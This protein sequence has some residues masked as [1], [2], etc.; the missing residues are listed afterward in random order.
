MLTSAQEHLEEEATWALG[1]GELVH[2]LIGQPLPSMRMS[3]TT[4]G[5]MDLAMLTSEPVVVYVHPGTATLYEVPE[6]P[7]GLL[8]S[9]CTVQS[10]V[11]REQ[12]PRFA[13]RRFRVAGISGCEPEAQRRFA[14]RERLAFPLLSDGAMELAEAIDLPTTL[15]ASGERVYTRLTFIAH[16]GVIDRVFYPVPIPRRNAIDVLAWL[17]QQGTVL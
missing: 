3:S 6:D 7:D 17:A 5:E 4:G 2:S 8:A 14:R 13:A 15:T 9:G 1:E 11:F 16:E 10:R 12:A